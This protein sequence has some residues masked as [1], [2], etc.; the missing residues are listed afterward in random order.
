MHLKL[1]QSHLSPRAL[2][3]LRRPAWKVA[4]NAATGRFVPFAEAKRRPKTT[5]VQTM[6][7]CLCR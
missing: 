6:H 7:V 1:T 4:R 5:V 2:M 3:A